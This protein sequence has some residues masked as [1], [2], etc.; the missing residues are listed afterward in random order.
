MAAEGLAEMWE[1]SNVIR[2][3]FRRQISFLQWPI[4]QA[5]V[6]GEGDGQTEK[7]PVCTKSLELNCDALTSMVDFY[8]GYFVDIYKVQSE[9]CF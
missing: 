3:R 2:G 4:H 7:H 5:D 1:A 8:H 6:A 9:A